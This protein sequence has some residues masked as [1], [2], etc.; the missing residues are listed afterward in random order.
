[1]TIRVKYKP[2]L[3]IHRKCVKCG[4]KFKTP[5]E[6][7]D[8]TRPEEECEACRIKRLREQYPVTW[9]PMETGGTE[10]FQIITVKK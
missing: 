1:M 6:S 10:G 9:W 7:V 2:E 5:Y 8:V 4:T 3:I